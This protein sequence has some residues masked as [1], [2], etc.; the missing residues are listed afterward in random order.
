MSNWNAKQIESFIILPMKG[1]R[2]RLKNDRNSPMKKFLNVNPQGIRET[3]QELKSIS[4]V[5]VVSILNQQFQYS[6]TR[7]LHNPSRINN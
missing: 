5:H 7:A 6:T 4:V 1:F 2:N 3:L